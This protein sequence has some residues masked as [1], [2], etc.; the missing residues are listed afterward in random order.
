MKSYT[1][2]EREARCQRLVEAFENVMFEMNGMV[3]RG[4]TIEAKEDIKQMLLDARNEYDLSGKR[5]TLCLEVLFI[6][7]RISPA[8]RAYLT[9]ILQVM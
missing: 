8:A 3:L 9:R 2:A 1:Q 5:Q 7:E 4:L 6:V